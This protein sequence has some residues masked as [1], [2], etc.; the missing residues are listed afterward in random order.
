MNFEKTKEFKNTNKCMKK[1]SVHFIDLIDNNELIETPICNSR[2]L[3]DNLNGTRRRSSL[4]RIN[5]MLTEMKI[6]DSTQQMDEK[7]NI[8]FNNLILKDVS[9]EIVNYVLKNAIKIVSMDTK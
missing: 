9:A 8:E 2:T 6:T 5:D 7:T 1:K 3:V 4:G